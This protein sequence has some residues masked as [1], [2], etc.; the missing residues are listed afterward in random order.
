ML[1]RRYVAVSAIL[2]MSLFAVFSRNSREVNHDSVKYGQDKTVRTTQSSRLCNEDTDWSAISA[3]EMSPEQMFEYL[4]WTNRKACDFAQ[5]FGGAV[6]TYFYKTIDGQKAVCMDPDVKPNS[7]NCLIYSFG[8]NN[9]WSFEKMFESYDCQVYAFDATMKKE[10][11]VNSDKIHF[12]RIGLWD[13]DTD[14]VPQGRKLRTLDAIYRM[15]QPLHGAKDI[16][17][18][19]IDIDS[20]E[21]M[22]L[23]QIMTTRMLDRIKQLAIEV[24]FMRKTDENFR[25]GIRILK[26]LEDYGMVRFS[27]RVNVYM[28]DTIDFLGRTDYFGYEIA[29]YNK[30]F[31]SVPVKQ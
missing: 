16:D 26:V 19:K 25:N 22:V 9:E 30:K 24:H 12:H 13:D 5:D 2:L 7:T 31:K 20:A 10:D 6:Y 28:N 21:W 23:P 4:H 29:W 8:I 1:P 15:L 14:N 17:Y 3:D 27:S 11:S 18:L